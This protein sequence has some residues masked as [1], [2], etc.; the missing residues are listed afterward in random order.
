MYWNLIFFLH[1]KPNKCVYLQVSEGEYSDRQVRC[2]YQHVQGGKRLHEAGCRPEEGDA[3]AEESQ[4][5]A[6]DQDMLKPADIINNAV[7]Q[8][9]AKR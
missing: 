1:L 4:S 6:T 9:R 7:K 2:V 3:E 5:E 8:C